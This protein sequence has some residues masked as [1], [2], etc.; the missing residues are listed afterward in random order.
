MGVSETREECI[1]KLR[2][3]GAEGRMASCLVH[4]KKQGDRMQG[5]EMEAP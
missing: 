2:T 1:F 5:E 4:R 3:A